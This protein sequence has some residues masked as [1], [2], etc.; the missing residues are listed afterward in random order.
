[1]D[2]RTDMAR[3]ANGGDKASTSRRR[4]FWVDPRFAIGLVLVVVS[5]GGVVALVSSANASV[6]I[7]AAR[8]TLTPGEHVTAAEL[9]PTSV[10]VGTTE[11]LYL[12][13]KDV[14]AAGVVMTRAVAAGELV[15][16]S[17][18]GSEGGAGLTSVVVSVNSALAASVAAGSRVDLWSAAQAGAQADAGDS[19]AAPVAPGSFEPPT[20]LVGS[21]IVVR[22]ID[23]KNLV[24]T[25]AGSSV[26]LLVPKAS[27][28]S[29]LDAIANGAA[30]SIVPV[31]LPLGQ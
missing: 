22:I 6:D 31:D 2:A 20:V 26:E 15:P 29:V 1:M 11:R 19:G 16:Q 14:P 9:V 27:T 8:A 25:G 4:S 12:R 17:A 24:T 30:L 3:T 28:A 7:L 13:A 21:A 18:V 23:Q 10:R 5:A